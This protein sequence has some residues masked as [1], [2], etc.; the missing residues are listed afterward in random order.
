[1]SFRTLD[2]A[3]AADYLHLT[4]SE[5]ENLLKTTDI[6]CERR[7]ERVIFFRTQLDEWA[8][9]RLLGL[10]ELRLTA[11]HQ[12]TTQAARPVLGQDALMPA[13]LLPE[14]IAP[15]MASKTKK[16]VLRDLVGVAEQTGRL[17]DPVEFLASLEAREELCSTGMPGGLALVHSRNLQPYRFESSFLLLGRTVQEIHFG[18]PDGRPTRLFFLLCCQDERLHLHALARLCLLVG[19]T[20]LVAQLLAAPDAAAMHAAL[21][22]AEATVLTGKRSVVAP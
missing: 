3:A 15:A 7:G 16:S 4:R 19:K 10:P 9:Q 14:F 22:A 6:P 2:L 20:N 12:K 13:L 11:Y 18:A 5:L 8:S 1:M 21:L 17:L